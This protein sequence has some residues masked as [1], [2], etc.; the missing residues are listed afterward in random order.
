MAS[1]WPQDAKVQEGSRALNLFIQFTSTF[2]F[3]LFY[4]VPFFFKCLTCLLEESLNFTD[5]YALEIIPF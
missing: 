2:L 4:Q 3:L 1:Q 5:L